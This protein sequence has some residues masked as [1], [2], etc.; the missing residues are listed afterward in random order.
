MAQGHDRVLDRRLLA[1]RGDA[2]AKSCGGHGLTTSIS[3][4]GGSGSAQGKTG[5]G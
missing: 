1:Y 3:R 4:K 5:L 2:K